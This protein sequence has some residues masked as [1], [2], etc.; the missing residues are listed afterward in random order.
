MTGLLAPARLRD[1]LEQLVRIP[2]VNPAIAPEEARGEEAVAAFAR[3]WLETNG[4]KA[5][6]EEAA[7][8]R[9][10]VVAEVGRGEGP[11]LVL[12]GHLDTVGTKGMHRPFAPRVEGD[13]L[14]GR[15]AYDMKCGVAA[16]MA[17]AAALADEGLPGRVM[18]ALVADEEYAS[19]GAQAFVERHRADACILTEPSEGQLVLAHKG[20]VW[21]EVITHGRAA[22]G[23]RWDLGDSAVARMGGIIAALDRFDRET[24]HRRTHD[25]VGPASMHCAMVQGG[26]GLST[27]APECRLQVERRTLPGETAASVGEEITRLVREV[28]ATAE[29]VVG[30]ARTPMMCPPDAA[31]AETVRTAAADVLGRAAPEVGVPFWMD[32]AIFDAAGIPT[33]NFG[34]AGA[35]AHETVEWVSLESVSVTAQVLTRSA[36]RFCDSPETGDA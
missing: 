18:L 12:C 26:V 17:A 5:W 31:I 25:L 2:S 36:R 16:C 4:V 13:R 6:E 3:G 24:L 10:N 8:R 30:L 7:P 29:V 20:F 1:L 15:G 34:A 11:T 28:D 23:S 14:Y 19:V 32:S 35:G 22:H 33:V 21:A 27:Y 9:P